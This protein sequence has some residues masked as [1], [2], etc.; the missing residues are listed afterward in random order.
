MEVIALKVMLNQEVQ[1]QPVINV[2]V[3][4][5]EIKEILD[6]V[7]RHVPVDIFLIE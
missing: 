6:L 4:T 7:H 5:I 1:I 2:L 3:L